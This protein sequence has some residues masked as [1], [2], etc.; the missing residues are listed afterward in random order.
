MN[1][2]DFHLAVEKTWLFLEE[3]I[4]EQCPDIDVIIHG[5]VMTLV[6]ENTQQI[7]INKQEPLRELWLASRIGGLHFK[8][9]DNQWIDS[10]NVL[11]FD[12]LKDA[13]AFCGE[14]IDFN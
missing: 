7:V 3:T 2:K 14:E 5:S 11:F 6:F 1:V 12:A 8:F 9:V 4:D 13:I 10:N